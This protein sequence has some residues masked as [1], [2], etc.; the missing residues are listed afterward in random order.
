MLKLGT[1]EGPAVKCGQRQRSLLDAAGGQV[2]AS[3]GD[4]RGSGAAASC[5]YCAAGE[6]AIPGAGRPDPGWLAHQYLC[7]GLSTYRIAELAGL[8][9]QRV[10][11]V[12]R[13]AGVP[14]RPRGAGRRRPARGGDP[15]G[16]PALM[17]ELYGT[18]RLS[19][20]Q[21]AAIVGMPE[22]TVR[23]RLRRYGI[24]TRTR[25]GWNREDRRIVPADVLENLYRKTGMTADE[26]G[27]RLGT[28]R[29][30]VLRSAHALGVPVRVGGTVALPGPEEIELVSTLYADPLVAAVLDAHGIPRVPP[31]G[32]VW[33]RFP[34]P[35]PLTTPL[36]KDLYWSCGVGLDHIEL[37]TGQPAI[38]VRRFMQRAGIPV[39]HP[40]GRTPFLRRWRAGEQPPVRP[41]TASPDMIPDREDERHRSRA[42][43]HVD[44]PETGQE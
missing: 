20:R 9:R 28:S 32:P 27:R 10:T 38:T 13:R 34:E 21:V 17:A 26:V 35:V 7:R 43:G 16:L 11:R 8:D 33:Q 29:G 44:R 15:P 6:D 1:A 41:S 2:L 5:R 36:V 14:L 23:T 18:L 40:G 37:L 25:G 39:R 19:S 3:D 12:L 30:T 22:R 42:V 31:G 24:R 4:T